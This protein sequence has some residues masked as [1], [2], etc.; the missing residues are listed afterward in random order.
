MYPQIFIYLHIN[1]TSSVARVPALALILTPPLT[2]MSLTRSIHC[3]DLSHHQAT[4]DIQRSVVVIPGISHLHVSCKRESMATWWLCYWQPDSLRFTHV[5]I[6]RYYVHWSDFRRWRLREK[7]CGN[8]IERRRR[9]I[10]RKRVKEN[11]SLD[12]LPVWYFFFFL[13]FYGIDCMFH[14]WD[15]MRVVR[16]TWV[17]SLIRQLL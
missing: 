8:I 14:D 6:S 13:S 7:P 10:R 4:L 5:W 16:N 17:R 1:V 2:Y 9:M 3:I 11:L 12:K 15:R